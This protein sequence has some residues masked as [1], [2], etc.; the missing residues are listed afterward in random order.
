VLF[1]GVPDGSYIIVSWPHEGNAEYSFAS[2]SY[3]LCL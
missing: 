3:M 2:E 1:D